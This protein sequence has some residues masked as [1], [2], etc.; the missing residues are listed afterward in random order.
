MLR[1][2]KSS[3]QETTQSLN[4]LSKASEYRRLKFSDIGRDLR[5]H[6]HP[7]GKTPDQMASIK[8]NWKLVMGFYGDVEQEFTLW[9]EGRTAEVKLLRQGVSY[10]L[11][12]WMLV[13]PQSVNRDMSKEPKDA[14][15]DTFTHS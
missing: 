9:L 11:N 2:C 3:I 14:L 7:A 5:D 15:T 4:E 12:T 1:I 6:Y 8:E 10:F 13:L